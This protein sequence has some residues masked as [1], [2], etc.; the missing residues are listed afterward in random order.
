LNLDF[1]TVKSPIAGGS[2][3]INLDAGNLVTADST[4]LTTVVSEDPMYLYFDIDERTVLR[5]KE[6]IRAVRF[7][8]PREAPSR[9]YWRADTKRS[10]PDHL[11]DAEN[12]PF[13]DVEVQVHRVS[14]TTVVSSVLSA[15]T[16]LP[17]SR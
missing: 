12:S 3:E 2:A 16:R 7:G 5:I 9:R 8:R 14:E 17:A 4:L 1:C 10:G 13:V 6:M 11:L 15:V